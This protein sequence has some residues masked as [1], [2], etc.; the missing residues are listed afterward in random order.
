MPGAS[1]RTH[2]RR[3]SDFLLLLWALAFLLF[4]G[5][6]DDGGRESRKLSPEKVP[7][8]QHAA[9]TLVPGVHLLGGM[10][11]TAAYAVE[12]PD[13]LVLIDS[14]VKDDASEVRTQLTE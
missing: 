3:P 5:C 14:G 7:H 9:I 13:G 12:T 2:L 1:S 6:E 10:T 4:A 11:L 8:L